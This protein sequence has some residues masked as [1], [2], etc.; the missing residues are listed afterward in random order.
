[1]KKREREGEAER[2]SVCV[3]EG[4]GERETEKVRQKEISFLKLVQSITQIWASK[5]ALWW[6]NLGSSQYSLL[7][8]LPLKTMLN[9][10]V[11]KKQL[12]N[13]DLASLKKSVTHSV[14]TF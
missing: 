8:Q 4:E 13:N 9:L 12:K 14:V 5:I 7:P 6:F 11:V 10:K 2:E 3:R 1:M